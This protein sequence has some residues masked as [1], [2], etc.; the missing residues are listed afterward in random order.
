MTQRVSDMLQEGLIKS[1]RRRRHSVPCAVAD[2]QDEPTNVSRL[3]SWPSATAHGTEWTILRLD[4]S[5][6]QLVVE[7][8]IVQLTWNV[9]TA[10]GREGGKWWSNST[11]TT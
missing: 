2:G 4:Q 9:S 8:P 7:M 5:F 11:R 10:K 6:L 3:E 1:G